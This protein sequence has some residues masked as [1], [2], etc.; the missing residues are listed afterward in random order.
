MKG[1]S[2]ESLSVRLQSLQKLERV[3]VTQVD[4]LA[5][6]IIDAVVDALLKP[7]LKRM[8]DRSEKCRESAVKILRRSAR[9]DS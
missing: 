3:L 7:L 9:F 8:K 4:S 2:E 6:D 5:T 1:L